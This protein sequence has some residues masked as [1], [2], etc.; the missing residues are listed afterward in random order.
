MKK[1]FRLKKFFSWFF[2]VFLCSRIES[3][4]ICCRISHIRCRWPCSF[5]ARPTPMGRICRRR[6]IFCPRRSWDFPV[7]FARLWKKYSL[8]C[9]RRW[10]CIL[11]KKFDRFFQ[12]D[13]PQAH[14]HTPAAFSRLFSLEENDGLALLQALYVRRCVDFWKDASVVAYLME[15]ASEVIARASGEKEREKMAAFAERYIVTDYFLR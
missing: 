13:I 10:L 1:K 2:L 4:W 3:I 11:K 7:Y 14:I 8:C 12:L 5:G 15:T 9:H 6:D